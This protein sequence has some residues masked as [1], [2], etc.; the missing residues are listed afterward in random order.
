MA[1][2]IKLTR[3]HQRILLEALDVSQRIKEVKLKNPES[4]RRMDEEYYRAA[5]RLIN[6]E[7]IECGRR[8]HKAGDNLFAWIRDQ[9]YHSGD[10]SETEFGKLAI[11]ICEAAGD[12]VYERYCRDTIIS[13]L[14]E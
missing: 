1:F 9:I 10:M 6:E 12:D 13:R 7:H 3:N 5:L 8:G 14:F 2:K 11:M 4:R